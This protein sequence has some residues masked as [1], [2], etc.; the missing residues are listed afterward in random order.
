MVSLGDSSAHDDTGH[1]PEPAAVVIVPIQL[2]RC[3]ES[4]RLDCEG[5]T[6]GDVTTQETLRRTHPVDLE[7][8]LG[9]TLVL[10]WLTCVL[11]GNHGDAEDGEEEPEPDE[12]CLRRVFPVFV[13]LERV[14]RNHS[15]GSLEL[16]I[17]DA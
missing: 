16:P 8:E 15:V 6:L 9:L 3:V 4:Q 2:R 5:Q 13:I 14:N 12:A 7:V 11:I 10:W 17:P 1:Y